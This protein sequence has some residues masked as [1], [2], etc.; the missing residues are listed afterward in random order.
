MVELRQAIEALARSGVEFVIV[1]GVAI[2]LHSSAY[3][4]YDLDFC[5]LRTRDNLQRVVVA[6]APF[7]PRPRGFP[8]NLPFVWDASTLRNGTNFTFTTDIGDIDLLGEVSGVGA[9]AEAI[10]DC[11]VME[12]YGCSVQVLSLDA[13]IRAKRAAGRT[14]DL[15][16]L[17]QLEALREIL[18]EE[19]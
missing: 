11:V 9:Y 2:T 12:L 16:V 7:H 17:P 14:K 4:T 19:N 6:L 1:G 13:L 15:L 18:T 3:I 5:Y 10:A 8:D